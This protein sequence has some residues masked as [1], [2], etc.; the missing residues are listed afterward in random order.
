MIQ[1]INQAFQ[2]Y[3]PVSTLPEGPK[4]KLTTGKS[5]AIVYDMG[6]KIL[7]VYPERNNQKAFKYGSV[8]QKKNAYIKHCK[9]ETSMTYIR[10]IRDI[11]MTMSLP[12]Q[13]SAKVYQY[14][15][16]QG[17]DNVQPYVLMEKIQG[18]ELYD[19][20]PT[21]CMQDIYIL[22]GFMQTLKCFNQSIQDTYHK[23]HENDLPACHR[24]LHP[25]NVFILPN[26]EVKLID[27]D[28]SICPFDVLRTNAFNSRKSLHNVLLNNVLQNNIAATNKYV[29]YDNMLET[30][31]NY[32]KQDADLYQIYSIFLYFK[33]HNKMVVPLV[34][35]LKT[36]KHKKQFIDTSIYILDCLLCKTVKF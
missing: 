18:I 34:V 22:S 3:P 7:K 6:D 24:D 1:F 19:Y 2:E 4:K 20:K 5:G 36:L 23:H 15:F 33:H 32:I 9:Y 10:S 35:K 25:H 30:I 17:K 16:V 12:D 26:N 31:P 27:F 14:G 8:M 28:L 13:I 11:V 29:K 21:G